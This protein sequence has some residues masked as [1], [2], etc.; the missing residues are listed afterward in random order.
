M[1]VSMEA[2]WA[3]AMQQ[4][5]EWG[6]FSDYLFGPQAVPLMNVSPQSETLSA[7]CKHLELFFGMLGVICEKLFS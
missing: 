7:G 6:L 5:E 3:N 1:S 4:S 2:Y